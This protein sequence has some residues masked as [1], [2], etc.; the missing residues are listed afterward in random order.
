M[1]IEDFERITADLK[2]RRIP[3]AV[4]TTVSAM[5]DKQAQQIV[6]LKLKGLSDITDFMV[7]CHGNSSRQNSALASEVKK[8]LAKEHKAKPFG[9]EG[10]READWILMD[11]VD[12]VVHIFEPGTRKKYALEKLWM[13][14]KRY[15]FYVD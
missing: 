14:A 5:L 1:K 7:L 13:D 8:R 6:V 10:E 9:V 2:K 3:T 4:K 15:N 12:F 11:Y